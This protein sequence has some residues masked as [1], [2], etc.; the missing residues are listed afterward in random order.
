DLDALLDIGKNM[1][2][3][4]ICVLSDSA[5]A[6]TASS[7]QKFRDEYIAHIRDGVCPFDKHDLAPT[8]P[9]PEVE[10]VH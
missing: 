2:G 4:T 9:E 1:S 6:P 5:A 10:I 3:T 7:I 8:H